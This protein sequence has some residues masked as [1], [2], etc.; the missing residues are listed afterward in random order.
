MVNAFNHYI[1]FIVRNLGGRP[2]NCFGAAHLDAMIATI[3]HVQQALFPKETGGFVEHLRTLLRERFEVDDVPLGWFFLPNA[4]GCLGLENPL[5]ELLAIRKAIIEDPSKE[6]DKWILEEKTRFEKIRETWHNSHDKSKNQ[7]PK[8]DKWT[9]TLEEF[10]SGREK[11][12]PYWAE[13]Y[14]ELLE[15]PD[16]HQ[17][18]ETPNLITAIKVLASWPNNDFSGYSNWSSI[19]FY[20]KWTL[21]LYC[22]DIVRRFGSLAVVDPEL[23]PVS[24]LELFRGAKIR[25]EQ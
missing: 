12:T 11:H 13:W 17:V 5:I 6:T 9:I 2:A 25:W 14:E 3:S 23:I 8:W 10:E 15:Y 19:G 21:A 20:N 16:P 22:D 7:D 4:L 18:D 24:M 1:R